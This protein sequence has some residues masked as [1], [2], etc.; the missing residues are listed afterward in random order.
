MKTTYRAAAIGRTGKGDYGHGLDVAFQ[1]PSD[2]I[3]GSD[4]QIV[5][6]AD[7]NPEGLRAAGRTNRSRETL[8]RLPR[9]AGKGAT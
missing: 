7:S 1:I 6:I 9:N 5:S 2:S 3:A 8:P 4:V